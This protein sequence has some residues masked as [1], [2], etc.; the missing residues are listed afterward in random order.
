M[1]RSGMTLVELLIGIILLGIMMTGIYTTF[2]SFYQGVGEVKVKEKTSYETKIGMSQVDK[3]LTSAGFG[4][5]VLDYA[6]SVTGSDGTITVNTMLG[7]EANS[8]NWMV[9]TGGVVGAAYTPYMMMDQKRNVLGSLDNGSIIYKCKDSD[10]NGACDDPYYYSYTLGL[11]DNESKVSGDGSEY[12]YCAAGTRNL[13]LSDSTLLPCV[14]KFVVNYR[15]NDT[16]QVAPCSNLNELGSVR[17]GVIYQEG[18][19]QERQISDTTISFN[20]IIDNTTAI[21]S[22]DLSDDMRY[23]RWKVLE[24]YLTMD[25]L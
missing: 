9:Y 2:I 4:I 13:N 15:C 11:S 19:I 24:N 1:N 17:Y 10:G 12:A 14:A 25:N 18:E 8:G 23:Y 7:S 6:D 5:S 16:W 21:S 20:S 22:I 3:I